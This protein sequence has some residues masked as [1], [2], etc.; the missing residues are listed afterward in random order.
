[1]SYLYMILEKKVKVDRY[2][3]LMEF[4]IIFKSDEDCQSA[5]FRNSLSTICNQDI[6]C[7]L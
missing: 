3:K 2:A 7:S 6:L 4:E 5:I 1:M